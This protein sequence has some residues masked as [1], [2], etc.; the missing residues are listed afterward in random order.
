MSA[1]IKEDGTGSKYEYYV[2]KSRD[3]FDRKF[4]ETSHVTRFCGEGDCQYG[5]GLVTRWGK[6]T[7]ERCHWGLIFVS[8][9]F[10]FISWPDF[11]DRPRLLTK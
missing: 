1:E 2:G 10:L 4:R 8:F 7:P 9:K 6:N 5:E 3:L 11:P